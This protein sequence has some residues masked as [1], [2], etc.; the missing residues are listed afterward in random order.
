MKGGREWL[1][2]E[3]RNGGGEVVA[4]RPER[5]GSRA[6]ELDGG[7]DGACQGSALG[8]VAGGAVV[9]S[10]GLREGSRR[11]NGCL[12]GLSHGRRERARVGGSGGG[13]G[14]ARGVTAAGDAGV[15][16]VRAGEAVEKGEE[17]R[18]GVG[19]E[20]RRPLLPGST[21][22]AE[23]EGEDGGGG[24]LEREHEGKIV[25]N[26]GPIGEGGPRATA[27]VATSRV[28]EGERR[29][30]AP[31]RANEGNA[32]VNE[33]VVRRHISG[34]LGREIVDTPHL[35]RLT[36]EGVVEIEREGR[37]RRRHVDVRV[38]PRRASSD[39]AR[40]DGRIGEIVRASP[41]LHINGVH[42]EAGAAERRWERGGRV[43]RAREEHE[44]P[45][46]GRE[47]GVGGEGERGSH[48]GGGQ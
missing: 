20:E 6:R 11:T 10:P 30:G 38:S 34:P 39:K 37:A 25:P 22:G 47:G 23:G 3:V 42:L 48:G 15:A 33:A 45:R 36:P 29:G 46:R 43:V 1:Q 16:G 5:G 35:T 9:L 7:A 19:A 27:D 14:G 31:A 12:G 21:K 24:P 13:D 32:E 17:R 44:G 26:G 8:G 2:G 18:E 4:G 28:L 40:G 41:D